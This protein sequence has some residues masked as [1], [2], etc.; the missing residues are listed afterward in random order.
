MLRRF[1]S[2]LTRVSLSFISLCLVADFEL[3]AEIK[4]ILKKK[5][6]EAK[7]VAEKSKEESKK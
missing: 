5:M 7:K 3:R 2:L 6:D 1:S 4:G